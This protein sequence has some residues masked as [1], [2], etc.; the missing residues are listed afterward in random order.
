MEAVFLLYRGTLSGSNYSAW[1]RR[2]SIM[3]CERPGGP[4]R[5]RTARSSDWDD[6]LC[7][8]TLLALGHGELDLLP[9]DQRLEAAAGDG[10]E[11]NKNVRS[12]LLSDKAK[13][14][15]FVEPLHLT[16]MRRHCQFLYMFR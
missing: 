11:M 8:R 9:L 15:R 3:D 6:V 1:W 2:R 5:S 13:A 10:A 7:L 4:G 16:S 14:L 12:L